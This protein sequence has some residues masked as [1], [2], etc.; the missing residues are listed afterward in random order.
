MSRLTAPI[1]VFLMEEQT[2]TIS[3]G[4]ENEI[5]FFEQSP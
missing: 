1:V 2:G 3:V 4:I 5:E